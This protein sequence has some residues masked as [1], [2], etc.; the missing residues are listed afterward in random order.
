MKR[1]LAALLV[2]ACALS[3]LPAAAFAE[4][5]GFNARLDVT[6]N[7][8]GSVSVTVPAENAAV[9]AEKQPTLSIPC[10]MDDPV[11]TL[12]GQPVNA[13]VDDEGEL[14]SFVVA[15]PGEYVISGGPRVTLVSASV[16]FD[17]L[18]RVKYYCDV[19][20][21]IEADPD[22]YVA[23][24]DEQGNELKRTP[25]SEG[26]SAEYNGTS[27]TAYYYGVV[28]KELEKTV[29]I[30]FFNGQDEPVELFTQSG[31]RYTPAG[32]PFS[33]NAYAEE[34]AV[35]G[36]TQQMRALAGAL[37]DYGAAAVTYFGGSSAVS[38]T[39]TAVTAADLADYTAI[40]DG[41]RP[42]G[43][44]K[45]QMTV[46]FEADNAIRINFTYDTDV[47]PDSF[48]YTIDGDPAELKTKQNGA[49]YITVPNIAA[50]KLGE[51]HTFSVSDGTNTYTMTV[52]VLSYAKLLIE[53]SDESGQ[54]LGKA[55]Y[56]YYSAAVAYF[57]QN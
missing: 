32:F 5:G 4:T 35:S 24:F 29:N 37:D 40:T 21:A 17:G 51:P 12:N 57:T 41:T 54:N 34:K 16:V 33:P 9:L 11:V 39:V 23:F 6:Q 42:A 25:L 45:T 46:M 8:D 52:S 14:L 30:R 26:V 19:P 2:A 1:F 47:N 43:I 49:R 15:E 44:K 18:I 10:D 31:K 38:E 3:V 53:R 7:E 13:S 56:R 50:K 22:A 28:P 55:L 48:T 20:A 36:S 27:Y